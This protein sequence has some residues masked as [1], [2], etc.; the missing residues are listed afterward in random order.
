M[1]ILNIFERGTTDWTLD[2]QNG[3]GVLENRT[4]MDYTREGG[5][6]DNVLLV[7]LYGQP[8]MSKNKQLDLRNILSLI[9]GLHYF[10]PPM[11]TQEAYIRM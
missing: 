5:Q 6:K 4:T 2:V 11:M 8:L 1:L 9:Y 7:V 3:V 10:T